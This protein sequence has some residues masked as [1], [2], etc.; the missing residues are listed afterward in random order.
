MIQIVLADDHQVVREGFRQILDAEPDFRVV[1]EAGDGSTA[2]ELVQHLQPTVLVLD[3]VMPGLKGLD[4]L[5]R[6]GA[7]APQTRS[8]VLSMYDD[9]GYVLQA[10]RSGAAAY[11]L[12]QSSAQELIQAMRTVVSGR[13]YLSPPLLEHVINAY[14]AQTQMSASKSEPFEVLSSREQDVLR[15]IA[16]GQTRGQIATEFSISPRTVET[17]CKRLVRKLHLRS[18]TD[19]VQYAIRHS[20]A[21]SDTP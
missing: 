10:L 17:Y 4:V 12:K 11:V 20:S 9:Q 6:V 18:H 21:P 14:L 1:G 13:H 15:R 16:G 2:V 3:M 7:C 8:V 5:A 19:L